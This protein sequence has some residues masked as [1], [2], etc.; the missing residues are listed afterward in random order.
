MYVYNHGEVGKLIFA[1]GGAE[2]HPSIRILTHA[3]TADHNVSLAGCLHNHRIEALG[4]LAIYS[5]PFLLAEIPASHVER[6]ATLV[7]GVSDP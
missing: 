7:L 3:T 2:F 4:V 5:C 6:N 1:M